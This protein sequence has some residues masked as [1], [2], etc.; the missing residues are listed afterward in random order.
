MYVN[1]FRY[2]TVFIEA[3]LYLDTLNLSHFQT[4]KKV[5]PLLLTTTLTC[6]NGIY[7]YLDD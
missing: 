7:S 6:E 2:Y 3:N 4:F 5:I 1:I